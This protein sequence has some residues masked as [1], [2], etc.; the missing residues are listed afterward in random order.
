MNFCNVKKIAFALALALA[1]VTFF[2][3]QDVI[4][5]NIRKEVKL[6]DASLKADIRSIIR[7]K[8][9]FYCANGNIYRKSVS[10]TRAGYWDKCPAPSGHVLKL[11]SD[12]TYIYALVGISKEDYNEGENVPVRRELWCSSDGSSWSKVT[13]VYGKGEIAGNKIE[14]YLFCTNA[15]ATANRKAYFVIRGSKDGV[16]RLAWSLNGSSATALALST[17]NA[18]DKPVCNAK[19]VSQ[20][21]VY[22]DGKVLFFN[23]TGSCTDESSKGEAAQFYYYGDGSRLKWGGQNNG[24]TGVSAKSNITSIGFTK[25]NLLVGTTSGITQHPLTSGIPGE[26]S[27]SMPYNAEATL[28]AQY[29]VLAIM[30]VTPEVTQTESIIYASQNYTGDGSNSAQFDHICM[31]SYYPGRKEWNRE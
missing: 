20:S 14:S 23:S 29:T 12:A 25:G 6:K 28:S 10:E 5:Y 4:F 9:F 31:W 19:A 7:Y 3:C 22:F 16:D 27:A 26:R 17:V 30:V 2:G 11:A 21:C 1:A 13:G 18:T 24:D 8:D 15:V